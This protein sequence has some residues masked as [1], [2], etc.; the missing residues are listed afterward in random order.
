VALEIDGERRTLPV[1][2]EL[3]AYRAVQHALVAVRS[4]GGEAATVALRYRPDVLE[5]E[6]RGAPAAGGGAEAALAAARERVT[7]HGGTFDAGAPPPGRRVLR[8]E[9]PV[10]AGG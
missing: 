4:A 1:G 7:A 10:A 8:A 3:A 6:V 9:L 5:L 2:V